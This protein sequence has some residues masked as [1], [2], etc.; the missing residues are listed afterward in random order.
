MRAWLREEDEARLAALWERADETRRRWVGDDVHLRGLVEISSHCRRLCAYCGLRAP[1]VA[2]ARYRLGREDILECADRARSFGFGTLV[3][4]SGED[5]GIEAEWLAEVIR[6]VR[7][8]TGLAVTLSLG[9][10]GPDE[11]SLWREAGADRYLLRFE[12]SNPDLYRRIHP[13]VKGGTDDRIG[14]LR[15]LR[16]LGYETGSGVMVGIPGQTFDDLAR[17]ILLFR[18][19]GLDMIGAGPFIPHPATPLG[20]PRGGA[21]APFPGPGPGVRHEEQVPNSVAM[22]LKTL[23]LARLACP[24]ANIP[25]TTALAALDP[26]RGR[27]RGLQC[28]A[29]VVMPNLTPPIFRAGYAIYPGKAC[30][31]ETVDAGWARLQAQLR[32]IGR[33]PGTGPGPSRRL[34]GPVGR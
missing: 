4:Q 24:W 31:G 30:P 7:A 27:E 29:N 2:L 25:S 23:A 32:S 12:T 10:R 33:R 9:E 15:S 8:R 34:E 17:D 11:L 5:P 6:Q 13:P 16:A 28:G 26:D 1:N 14:L 22:T 21:G 20:A 18:D 3:M 19:L